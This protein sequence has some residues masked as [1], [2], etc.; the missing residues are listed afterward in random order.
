MYRL[1]EY[2]IRRSKALE[3][4]YYLTHAMQ[5][6]SIQPQE[7]YIPLMPAPSV[8]VHPLAGHVVRVAVVKTVVVRCAAQTVTVTTLPPLPPLVPLPFEPP[9]GIDPLPPVML[10]P[11]PPLP[12]L[13]APCPPLPGL[14]APCPLLPF[15]PLGMAPRL[16]AT[17]PSVPGAAV[18][19]PTS[20][21]SVQVVGVEEMAIHAA[22]LSQYARQSSAGLA[23]GYAARLN[24]LAGVRDITVPAYVELQ[25]T[26]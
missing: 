19:P 3:Y 16:A 10:A 2:P 15:V 23:L 20:L 18:K 7:P 21:N 11:W 1:H 26:V 8:L 5:H 6:Q 24:W 13:L 25:Y 9:V 12:V 22:K 4:I 17:A 14:L